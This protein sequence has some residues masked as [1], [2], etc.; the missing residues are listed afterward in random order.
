MR[1][2]DPTRLSPWSL[3]PDF[4]IDQQRDCM[5]HILYNGGCASDLSAAVLKSLL[6]D[7]EFGPAADMDACIVEMH[8][9]FVESNCLS[10]TA[11]SHQCKEFTRG[12]LGMRTETRHPTFGMSYKHAHIKAFVHFAAS[13]ALLHQDTQFAKLRYLCISSLSVFISFCE[14]CPLILQ[15]WQRK[16]ASQVGQ[17]FLDCYSLLIADDRHRAGL[18]NYVPFFRDRPK[19]HALWHHVQHLLTSKMN[20]VTMLSCWQEEDLMGRIVRI[21]KRCHPST[22]ALRTLQRWVLFIH[23]ELIEAE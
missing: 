1:S 21:S 20:V 22:N 6:C 14:A 18:P 10:H 19:V 13:K 23:T 8:H 3:V 2:T 4:S 16:Y 12:R 17:R 9:Q 15:E 5:Q 11:S 7:G